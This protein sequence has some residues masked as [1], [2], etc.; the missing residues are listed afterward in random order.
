MRVRQ[1]TVRGLAVGDYPLIATYSPPEGDPVTLRVPVE[2]RWPAVDRVDISLL[3]DARFLAGTSLRLHAR[4]VPRGRDRSSGG[5]GAMAQRDAR[6][7]LGG[8][9]WARDGA[10]GPATPK[11]VASVEG[12]EGQHYVAGRA[13]HRRVP[14]D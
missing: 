7:C 11:I 6:C 8:P 2:I 5:G 13:V 4:A 14:G 9:L 12:A 1:G 10:G 3:D